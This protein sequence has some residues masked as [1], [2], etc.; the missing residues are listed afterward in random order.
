[1]CMNLSPRLVYHGELER[2]SQTIDNLDTDPVDHIRW[3][4][5][6]NY[7]IS[8]LSSLKTTLWVLIGSTSAS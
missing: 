2:K 5:D 3:L 1:M 6:D 4:F 7:G 8:L